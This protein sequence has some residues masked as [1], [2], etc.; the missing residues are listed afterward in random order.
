MRIS[1]A[2]ALTLTAILTLSACSGVRN[3]TP[4][5]ITMPEVY[6]PGLEDD[7]AC[8]ADIDWWDFYA[9][10]TLCHLIRLT[11]D[12]NRDLLKAASRVEE[13]RQLYCIDKANMLPEITGLVSANNETNNYSV[14]GVVKDPEYSLKLTVGWETNLWGTLSWAKRRGAANFEASVEDFHAMRM[15]LIAEVATGYFRL[16]ALDNE[17]TIVRQTLAT[18]E[19]SL[20]QARIRFEGG[21]TS[22]TV[23][24][25][26]KVEY[27]S[28]AS[29]VPNLERETTAARNALTLLMGEYPREILERGQLALNIS[30]PEKL[31]A[32][33]PSTLLQRRPD[34]RAAERRL[35]AAM[36]GV[37]V[38]YADRFPNLRLAFT[39]GFENDELS[40]FFKSPFTYAIGTITGSLFD[41][42]RKK[43]KY[44]AAIAEYDQARYDYEKA[45]ITA[46]TDVN[47][48]ID[49]YNRVRE[50]AK[51]KVELRD[52]TVKYVQ[53]AHL[54]YRAGTL[55]YIDVLDAQRRYFD[56]Q[57]GVSNALRDQYFALINLY[58]S[59]G[60]GWTSEFR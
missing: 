16:I 55:N 52:A 17:L 59:L 21:L 18:R 34:L 23:Y 24:Q 19:Q 58:K 22:E 32:G 35:A 8:I 29:L 39:P 7:S 30:L 13:A 37:G 43:R 31:P 51:L 2:I 6:M 42:G 14:G 53:L 4:P 49:T 38:S 33:V 5:D 15:A 50:S 11:L 1:S 36:S 45:V 44:Q 47:T 54:Q 26:A 56:A 28:T 9:D 48:A 57:I 12:N 20:E 40:G 10:S 60:G 41:F 27:A 3:L 25:Q 46:F